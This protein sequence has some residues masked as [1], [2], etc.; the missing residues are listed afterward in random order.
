MN[1]V[2][3][4]WVLAALRILAPA[5]PFA[6]TF[7]DTAVAIAA[8]SN[9]AP[10]FAGPDGPKETAA[11]VASLGWFESSLNPAA[12]G[13]CDRT[14]KDGT[15]EAGSRPHSFCLL[16]I[17]E[18]NHAGLGVTRAELLSDVRACVRAGLRMMR[19]SLALCRSRPLEERLRWYAAGG[20]TCSGDNED[21]AR[22]S[23]H[24]VLKG[25]WLLART[26]QA[27]TELGARP[28]EE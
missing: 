17:H 26:E 22:K 11:L 5:S 15:C 1:P 4:S 6:E 12:E 3:A 24:R 19:Q 27:W 18:S 28:P 10:L 2:H 7:D 13:D 21:A 9:A 20:S 25:K 8:E 14:K 16:Q 23:R